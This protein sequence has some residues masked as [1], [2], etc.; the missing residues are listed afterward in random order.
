MTNINDNLITKT[1]KATKARSTT[2]LT[3]KSLLVGLLTVSLI[4]TPSYAS[5]SKQIDQQLANTTN[6]AK[7]TKAE[8]HNEEIG[9][10]TGAIIGAIL[11]GPVGAFVTGVAGSL[12]A[13]N[14]NA[15]T[16]IEKLSTAYQKE[17]QGNQMAL[18]S[19]QEKISQT[20]QAYQNELS[21]LKQK[22]QA[23]SLLQAENLLMSLQ[24]STGSS[25]IKPHYQAQIQALANIIKQS[26]SLAVDLKGYTDKQ[27]S[28]ALNLALSKARIKAVKNA[29]VKQGVNADNIHLFAYGEQQPVVAS[30]EKEISFYDR[31]VVIKLKPQA[32]A[33]N[34]NNFNGG[35]IDK[36][37]QVAKR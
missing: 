5:S 7:T 11:G 16:K 10:G 34:K 3:G 35:D 37:T 6:I 4:T 26:P 17:K 32:V 21:V 13:K 24:F 19:Y 36:E 15:E 25:E 14:V 33:I 31:R 22:Y 29:L 2:K 12:I 28:E 18:V 8:Q 23:A 30:N 9:F 1:L 20:E 27:G